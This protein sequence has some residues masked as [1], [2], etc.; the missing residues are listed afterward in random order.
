MTG[1]R[2]IEDPKKMYFARSF[3]CT[4]A[5]LKVSDRIRDHGFGNRSARFRRGE[6]PF[7]EI[8]ME[9]PWPLL[10][11]EAG[12][13]NAAA[14]I[15]ILHVLL[16][17]WAPGGLAEVARVP[18]LQSHYAEHYLESGGTMGWGEFLKLH[19]V[20]P[21]HERQDSDRHGA[22]PFHGP[23]LA[24]HIFLAPAASASVIPAVVATQVRAGALAVE[25]GEWPGRSVF[26]PP[27]SIG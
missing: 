9:P 15:L 3:R 1:K 5:Q 26:H 11:F 25:V 24:M 17:T 16:S 14:Y 4:M 22:L 6:S 12:M 2:M 27:K 21:E 7:G 8:V 20:D 23:S 19:F 18:S 10:T 13:K